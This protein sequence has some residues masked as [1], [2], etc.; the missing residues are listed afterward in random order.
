MRFYARAHDG[1]GVLVANEAHARD[2]LG[3]AEQGE[4][5][6]RV[7]VRREFGQYRQFRLLVF[8]ER[9]LFLLNHP[10]TTSSSPRFRENM[11][12][13][14]LSLLHASHRDFKSNASEYM[15]AYSDPLLSYWMH[16]PLLMSKMRMMVPFSEA[17]AILNPLGQISNAHK[18]DLW[19]S[20]FLR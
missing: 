13:V 5:P 3:G 6:L 10:K 14:P 16:S 2:L 9:F 15:V 1:Q 8:Y 4:T 11:W 7:E 18:V 12:M 20:I 19:A 17:V